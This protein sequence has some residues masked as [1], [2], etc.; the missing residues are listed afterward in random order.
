MQWRRALAGWS[1]EWNVCLRVSVAVI[2][3]R[4]QKRFKEE[5]VYFVLQLSSHISSLRE[6]RA[7]AQGRNLEAGVKAEARKSAAYWLAPRGAGPA[8][9]NHQSRKWPQA[10]CS[11]CQV[12]I[13]L[14]RTMLCTLEVCLEKG[15]DTWRLSVAGC[16]GKGRL[17]PVNLRLPGPTSTSEKISAVE[18]VDRLWSFS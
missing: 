13:K 16:W 5:G 1:D 15:Q 4:D 3:D 14:V 12:D 9:I 18:K 10:R 2:K 6:V 11:T 17:W 8:H 7:G